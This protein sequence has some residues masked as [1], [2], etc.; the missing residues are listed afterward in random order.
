MM[1]T[2]VKTKQCPRCAKSLPRTVEFFG[3]GQ[4]VDGMHSWCLDCRRAYTRSRTDLEVARKRAK[5]WAALNPDAARANNA[6]WRAANPE[7][8]RLTDRRW[9]EA[10]KDR[11]AENNKRWRI[12]NRE[13]ALMVH[14]VNEQRRRIRKKGNGGSATVDQI[15]A[16]ILYFGSK[17]WM[18]GAPWECLDH[19]IPVARGGTGW[20]SNIRPACTPCNVRKGA[21]THKEVVR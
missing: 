10:N 12:E 15:M 8:K 4:C 21:R 7:Q 19:V 1:L 13:R 6:R 20:A 11:V 16:R 3:K 5:K 18:C 17:C 14:R 2:E 9:Y